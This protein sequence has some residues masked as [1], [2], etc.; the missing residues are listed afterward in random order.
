MGTTSIT[1]T[2]TTLTT[3]ST[4]ASS[5]T[6]VT[7]TTT[8]ISSTTW[9][10]TTTTESTTTTTTTTTVTTTPTSTQTT[11]PFIAG[12]ECQY[13]GLGIN[14]LRSPSTPFSSCDAQANTLNKGV[15]A[16]ARGLVSAECSSTEPSIE[17]DAI[18]IPSATFAGC[19]K[20]AEVLTDDL[21][22]ASD[23][24]HQVACFGIVLIVPG[25][26]KACEATVKDLNTFATIYTAA[27]RKASG[28]DPSGYTP[29]APPPPS[30]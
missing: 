1:Y 26:L 8:T 27:G 18:V 25:D 5:T 28:Q 6:T 24:N 14:V 23:S 11:T 29:H 19:T 3:T 16:A 4:T 7:S 15:N 10:E 9:A 13:I 21:N 12:F 20:Y 2:T 30:P 22:T 17:D